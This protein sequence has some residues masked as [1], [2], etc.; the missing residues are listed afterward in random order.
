M[1]KSTKTTLAI[2]IGIII[3]VIALKLIF[4]FWETAIV[5]GVAFIFG[6]VVAIRRMKSKN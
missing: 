1:D 2:I 4:T 6:Y 3:I 5:G